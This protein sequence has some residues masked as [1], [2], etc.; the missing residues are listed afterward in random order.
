MRAYRSDANKQNNIWRQSILQKLMIWNCEENI[1][2]TAFN[3]HLF[4]IF[5]GT[6]LAQELLNTLCDVYIL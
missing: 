4:K 2:K 3:N 1:S 5:L 6:F